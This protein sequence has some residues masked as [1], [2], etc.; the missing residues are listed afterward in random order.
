MSSRATSPFQAPDNARTGCGSLLCIQGGNI[1]AKQS[2]LSVTLGFCL[3][4]SAILLGTTGWAGQESDR[5]K[6]Q[7]DCEVAYQACKK[8]MNANQAACSQAFA[9]CKAACKDVKP[10]PSPTATASP[11]G[12]PPTEPAPT[13]TPSPTPAGTPTGS[14]SPTP[15]EPT[16]TPSPR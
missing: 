10:H 9:T 8:P 3:I 16:P 4:L 2:K 13:A 14:P 15:M 5:A 11:D 6:C 12:T 1:V 7:K